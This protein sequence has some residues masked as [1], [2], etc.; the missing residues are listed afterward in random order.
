MYATLSLLLFSFDAKVN[1]PKWPIVNADGSSIVV[2]HS[3]IMFGFFIV[4]FYLISKFVTLFFIERAKLDERT[5][6]TFEIRGVD[7]ATLPK[8]LEHFNVEYEAALN[9]RANRD[10]LA[11]LSKIHSAFGKLVISSTKLNLKEVKDNA[12]SELKRL[13]SIT[14][15][16]SLSTEK[17][18]NMARLHNA[19]SAMFPLLNRF[20]LDAAQKIESARRARLTK[21]YIFDGALPF[22]VCFLGCLC[23]GISWIF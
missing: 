14:M 11:N 1:L 19:V 6:E 17:I 5:I 21:F 10:L 13:E 23:S 15:Q 18:T 4:Q 22:V 12:E 8:A 20:G 2:E 16:L 9:E 3:A 7:L